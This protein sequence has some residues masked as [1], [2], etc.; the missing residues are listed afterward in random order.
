L[1]VRQY[2]SW[3]IKHESDALSRFCPLIH[4]ILDK[5]FFENFAD[6][7]EVGEL[8]S[9]FQL[10]KTVAED[11]SPR[12]Q[13]S[14]SLLETMEV[15]LHMLSGNTDAAAS[16]LSDN[17]QREAR[18]SDMSSGWQNLAQLH[19][20]LYGLAVMQSDN[21]DYRKG[22]QHLDEWWKLHQ[23]VGISK[24]ELCYGNLKYATC[25]D[26]L[27]MPG[28]AGRAVL[29]AME[30]LPMTEADLVYRISQAD[31]EEEKKR[32]N[33]NPTLDNVEEFRSWLLKEFAAL[34]TL[35]IFLVS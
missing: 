26:G 18:S 32:L 25:Y 5:P 28:E 1:T 33:V 17:L 27:K 3:P 12:L 7:Q 24:Q 9:M 31:L 30:L 6:I 15:G 29:K 8:A 21:P 4:S 22:I 14:R 23:G 35:D 13:A 16:A 11:D 10:L 34:G 2:Y 20:Q 19:M